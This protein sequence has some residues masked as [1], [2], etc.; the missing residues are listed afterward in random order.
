[1]A[2]SNDRVFLVN[3]T[4][5]YVKAIGGYLPIRRYEVTVTVKR[6]DSNRQWQG[7]KK[8]RSGN[9]QPG[10]RLA[11]KPRT[12]GEEKRVKQL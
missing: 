2:V 3:L 8:L 9:E 6:R 11:L 4:C 12:D 1:M 7:T 5:S 10:S